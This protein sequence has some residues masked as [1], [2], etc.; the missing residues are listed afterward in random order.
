MLTTRRRNLIVTFVLAIGLLCLPTGAAAGQ[1]QKHASAKQ[2]RSH[3]HG[4]RHKK[5][6]QNQ[7]TSSRL[8]SSL[9]V[10]TLS[11]ANG[12][13]V[14]GSIDW[15]VEV[16]GEAPTKVSFAV[17]GTA[18]SSVAAAPYAYG[19]TGSFDTTRLGN[20]TH[21]LTATAYAKRG[22]SAKSSVTVNVS[23]VVSV[24]P[25]TESGPSPEPTPTPTPTPEPAPSVPPADS[26]YW[27]AWIG[28]Q[29]TGEEA[30]WDMNAV[31]KFESSVGKQL[32]LVHFSSPF[33]NCY[34]SP[35]KF[36]GLPTAAF[37]NVRQAGAI[38]F[39]SWAS[40]A[41]PASKSQPDFQLSDVTA[42][43]YDSYIR[44]FATS[45]KSWGHPFFLRFN[46]EM[47]GNWFPWSESINGNGAG[48][49]VAAWRHVHDIFASVGATNAT[50]VWCPNID[51]D[52]RWQNLK[53][54]YPGDNYVDWTCLDGYNQGTMPSMPD[55]WRTFDQLFSS[56]YKK[57]VTEIAPSKPMVIGEVGS[58]EYGGSKST[59]IKE[60]FQQLPASYPSVY[61]LIWFDKYTEGDWPIDS[62]TGA[63][64]AFAEGIQRSAYVPDAT[65]ILSAG[66]SAITAPSS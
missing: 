37:E 64:Q 7:V 13:T 42:G 4:R 47:N 34:S 16:A 15:R 53:S 32:S 33:A 20:G 17:D 59:W 3:K 66:L 48:Q 18:Q 45:A 60:M 2:K 8:R 27:G 26:M 10:A 46:W 11:P 36:Y 41:L 49:Y 35:C 19:G 61:G 14:S 55:R 30:P 57:I 44:S 1:S 6:G 31:S 43:T 63:T 40:S 39:F 62:S 25:P 12:A 51:P 28:K 58:T 52:N 21:T 50:W 5:S 65:S 38:P 29:L 56:T 9:A 24:P 23:N 22:I 54:I